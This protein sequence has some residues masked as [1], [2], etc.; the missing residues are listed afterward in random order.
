MYG[1][2]CTP[3]VAVTN[4]SGTVNGTVTL[5]ATASAQGTYTVA[6]VQFRVDGLGVG[7]SITAA[8]YSYAWNSTTVSDGVHQI[9]A[10]VTDSANQ[11]ATSA[12]VNLT[13]SNGSMAVTLSADQLFPEPRTTAT[14]SGSFSI[15]R[16]SGGVGGGVTL[17]GVMPL[18]VELG[19]AYAGAESAALIELASNASN[20]DRWEVPAGIT[21]DSQQ[22]A[23]LAAGKLYVLV[24]STLNADGELRGQLLPG[25]IVVKFATLA[26]SAEV[27][28]SVGTSNG[29]VV[30]TVDAVNLRAAANINVAGLAATG[31]EIASGAVGTVGTPL[32]TLAVDARDPDHFLNE[33]ISLTSADVA[34]FTNGQW[35]GNVSSAAHPAGEQRGQIGTIA[36]A[37]PT[38]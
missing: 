4:A 26:G 30:V 21:L 19:D 16:S 24:R 25:G 13:V 14:G 37:A 32:A 20:P 23:D 15:D 18:S 28:P 8:P 2:T 22:L 33:A 5:A 7:V 9:T 12:P 34:N 38:P 27:P 17:I 29:Q 1:G 10:V 11:T 3:A 36:A 31:A 6:S 35:Y